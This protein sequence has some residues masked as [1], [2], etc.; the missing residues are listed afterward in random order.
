MA[1]ENT[2]IREITVSIETATTFARPA[3]YALTMLGLI[4]GCRFRFVRADAVLHYGPTARQDAAWLPA[5]TGVQQRLLEKGALP[6]SPVDQQAHGQSFLSLFPVTAAAPLSSDIIA[7][8]FFFLSLHEQWSS[9]ARDRFDRFPAAASLLGA[10][11]ELARP[12]LAEYALQ[13]RAVLRSAGHDL[14]DT[15]R[16]E[17]RRAAAVMTHDI[18]YLSKFTAG[19]LFRELVKNFL[20]NRRHVSGAER[21]QRLREYLGFM[22]EENDPYVQSILRMLAVEEQRGIRGS[23][24]FKAGGRDR[25]DVSY[26]LEGARARRIIAL[27]REKGHD[28][29][30][31]PSFHA[32]TDAAMLRREHQRLRSATD[33]DLRSVRQH[34]LRF[35]YPKTWRQ[36]AAENFFVDSTLGFAEEEGFRNGCCHPFLP[37]DLDRGEVLPI[38]EL[39]LTVMDGT[40][41]QY[42]GMTP[43]DA[44][45]RIDALLRT[46]TEAG[47]VAV[48]LF[49]NT[50]YDAHDFPGWGE[51]FAHAAE[52]MER[53]AMYSDTLPGTVEAWLRSSAFRDTEEVMQ[54]INSEPA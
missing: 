3:R 5:A 19:L 32:H 45:M 1:Q 12:V 6:L 47:G 43:G 22:R 42:R 36:Q 53:S 18:D 10:R 2:E 49:H 31:H 4:A 26:R 9:A 17:G 8:A 35:I 20:F 44:R 11:G 28:I 7:A 40:L 16:Y 15:G 46:V 50:A 48:L 27:L 51:V 23:W 34:Y 33:A 54:V 21:L 24:L 14:P 25:R 37:W 52:S 13:L 39:P 30:L 41:A 38:W 29:G